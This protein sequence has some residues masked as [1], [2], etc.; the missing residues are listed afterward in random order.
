MKA[1]GNDDVEMP[2]D[3]GN[4]LLAESTTASTNA[5][6]PSDHTQDILM[7]N[8]RQHLPTSEVVIADYLS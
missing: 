7:S 4:F 5:I 8:S 3:N 1:D 2:Y 6:P